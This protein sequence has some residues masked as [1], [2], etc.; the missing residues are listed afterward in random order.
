MPSPMVDMELD[1]EDKLDANGPYP[2]PSKPDY[3]YGLQ[4]CLTHKEFEKLGLD[5]SEA[6]VGGICHLHALARITSV[7]AN[8][9]A[10][11]ASCR[12]EMQITNLAIESEDEENEDD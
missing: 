12:V 11:G 4:I 3:P 7:S 5:P 8:D 1:D 2:L 6:F 9:G 10:S